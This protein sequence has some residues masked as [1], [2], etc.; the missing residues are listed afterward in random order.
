MKITTAI[1]GQFDELPYVRGYK[2]T[3]LMEKVSFTDAIYLVLNGQ[4]PSAK[5]RPFLD[6]L[7]IAAI[8]HGAAPIYTQNA[9]N[10]ASAGGSTAAA[11]AAGVLGTGEFTGGAVEA[12]ARVLQDGGATVPVGDTNAVQQT[13]AAIVTSHKESKKRIA[14]YGHKLYTDADPRTET[15]I[16]QAKKLGFYGR[17]FEL[18]EAIERE[19]ETQLGKKLVFNIDGALAAG[20]LELGFGAD[21]ANAFFIISRVPGL[22]AH[23]QEERLNP[24]VSRRQSEEEIE[25][26]GEKP[27][28]L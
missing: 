14:G 9:R 10:T 3:D 25:Y 12:C 26:R 2:I 16:A 13:A 23:I 18:A 1:T 21:T 27:R 28:S 24:P 4:L 22:A 20:I 8:D 6:V 17:Y 7:L 19:L 15:I 5:A 11:I